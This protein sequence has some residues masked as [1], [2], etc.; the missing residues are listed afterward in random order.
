M[1]LDDGV[2]LICVGAG[3]KK[4]LSER[5]NRSS[6]VQRGV[7]LLEVLG[8]VAIGSVVMVGVVDQTNRYIDNTKDA[9]TAEHARAYAEAARGYIKE[10]KATLLGQTAAV[11]ISADDLNKY[12]ATGFSGANPYG[13]K[14]VLVVKRNPAAG[15]SQL[16]AFLVYQNG[17]EIPEGRRNFV[18]AM[19]G[20]G[21]GYVDA[22]NQLQ[23]GGWAADG[24]KYFGKDAGVTANVGKVVVAL[25]LFEPSDVLDDRYL[26]RNAVLSPGK[27]CNKLE[28]NLIGNGKSI[29]DLGSL[30][31]KDLNASGTT[32]L[33]TTNVSGPLTVSST[34]KVEGAVTINGSVTADIV[35]S[36]RSVKEDSECSSGEK[37]AIARKFEAVGSTTDTS[38]TDP[39]K[40]TGS[41]LICR[42]KRGGGYAWL[43]LIYSQEERSAILGCFAGNRYCAATVK[44]MDDLHK[45]PELGFD[46]LPKKPPSGEYDA[47]VSGKYDGTLNNQAYS[48]P[49]GGNYEVTQTL[50]I[51]KVPEGPI[52]KYPTFC[53]LGFHAQTAPQALGTW[54]LGTSNTP[55]VVSYTGSSTT[56]IYPTMNGGPEHTFCRVWPD[57]KNVVGTRGYGTSNLKPTWKIRVGSSNNIPVACHAVCFY[58]D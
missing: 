9:Y 15:V 6:L 30:T 33:Y 3:M 17:N 29:T 56:G 44:E 4:R 51:Q 20:L 49:K 37:G 32:T 1:G 38:S 8:S 5:Q 28:S 41:I 13:Q 54:T 7:S 22:T 45:R 12:V 42:E 16:Q 39:T 11:S 25:D 19:T 40:G 24:Q 2:H 57:T 55:T 21:G 23:G 18:A 10:N 53:A 35:R 43:P 52:I 27:D 48:E 58:M 36:S 50:G 26:C 47:T 31:T 46:E 14:P 34:V